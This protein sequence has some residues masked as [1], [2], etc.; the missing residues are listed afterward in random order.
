MAE[1]I[2]PE[3]TGPADDPLGGRR[4][5]RPGVCSPGHWS[6]GRGVLTEHPPSPCSAPHIHSLSPFASGLL[7]QSHRSLKKG[8]GH[9]NYGLV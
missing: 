3:G 4:L 1:H 9:M 2:C 5:G 7:R 8:L 6:K